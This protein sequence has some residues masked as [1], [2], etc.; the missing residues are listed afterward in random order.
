LYDSNNDFVRKPVDLF[1]LRNMDNIS[2]PLTS[3][4]QRKARNVKTA[5]KRKPNQDNQR[6]STRW[7][8]SN[9]HES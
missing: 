7:S 3:N 1:R 5:S 6:G 8:S 4:D 2:F 9:G